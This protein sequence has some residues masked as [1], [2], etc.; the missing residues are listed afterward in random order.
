M[1]QK[2]K[3]ILDHFDIPEELVD[4]APIG[5]GM[6][7]DTLAVTVRTPGG[8]TEEKYI[9]Q[10]INNHVFE[11]VDTLQ[12]N[13]FSVTKHIRKKLQTEG[14]RDID[15]HVLTFFPTKSGAPY[16]RH[17]DD[18][19][20]RL[21]LYI[22][23]SKTYE[24]V[25]P[26]LA[27][28]AGKA[29]GAFQSHLADLPSHNLG[30][31]I[32]RFHDMAFRLDELHQAIQADRAGRVAE[33]RDLIAEIE[34]RSSDMLLQDKLHA[35]GK[36]PKRINHLDTKVNNILFD[37]HSDKV[38]CVI[39]L[40]TVMPGYV[41]SDIGDFIRTAVNTAAEDEEDLSKVGVNM[42][43]FHA[44]T[45]GYMEGARD[46]LTPTEISLLPYGGRLL[47]YMQTVRFLTD[48]LN[49]DI[50]YKTAKPKHN[51]IRAKA[52]FE[53]LRKLEEKAQEMD[54]FMERWL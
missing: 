17:S 50:Y 5:N 7:N 26:A 41:L 16:H 29:F 12:S 40:D 23:G 46:F 27:R 18:T 24:T 13:I 6:I 38:L 42:E 20:W 45:E 11:D 47:T 33:V 31:T 2:F 21:S 30:E 28:E 32:P 36:L 37:A 44:Y 9:L 19:Y 15:R 48:Y 1:D 14:D 10:R 4:A 49:G 52:Q 35:E 54:T 25:T 22:K 39:D 53:F 51:L 43:I 3:V 34:K 8:A